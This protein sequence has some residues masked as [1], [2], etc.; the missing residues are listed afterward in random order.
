MP[1]AWLRNPVTALCLRN[2][3][4]GK[5]PSTLHDA[6]KAQR[7]F[8]HV[9]REFEEFRSRE[10]SLTFGFGF[11]ELCFLEENAS[12]FWVQWSF[13]CS[14]SECS[15]YACCQALNRRRARCAG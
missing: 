13:K 8:G 14:F 3:G 15:L 9:P 4:L 5:Q 12:G 10:L 2:G 6:V 1:V 7:L 11:F